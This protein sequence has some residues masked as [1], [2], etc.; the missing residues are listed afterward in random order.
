MLLALMAAMPVTANACN[1][2][3][4]DAR[5][6]VNEIQEAYMAKGIISGAGSIHMYLN[7]DTGTFWYYYD[8]MGSR[9]KLYLT[10]SEYNKQSRHL[11]L[12]EENKNGDVTGIFDGY[13]KS[14]GW[15]TG[16]FTN[17]KG[18]EFKFSVN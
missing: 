18:Q 6:E 3:T 8:K 1:E 10:V 2:V 16:T 9:N 5:I 15:Y 17:Y 4:N 7:T 14:N 11:V 13:I 12:V